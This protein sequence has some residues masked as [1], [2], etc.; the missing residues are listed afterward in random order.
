MDL[1]AFSSCHDLSYSMCRSI[2]QHVQA[3]LKR[4]LG[5]AYTIYRWLGSSVKRSYDM[6]GMLS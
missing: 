4:C 1:L 5:Q 3:G 2:I 6:W